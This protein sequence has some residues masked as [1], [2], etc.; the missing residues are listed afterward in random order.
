MR[1]G[2]SGPRSVPEYGTWTDIKTRCLNPNASNY[3][4]YGGRGITICKRWLVFENFLADM[5]ERPSSKHSIERIDNNGNYVPVNCRWATQTQQA[6]NKRN[7]VILTHEGRTA[8]IAEWSEITGV[9]RF[10]LY[11]RIRL[12]KMTPAEALTRPVRESVNG[13][14]GTCG[15]K[16]K[17]S[18]RRCRGC[19]AYRMRQW[20]SKRKAQG[21]V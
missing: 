17:H 7:N 13:P 15:R 16:G 3:A 10:T 9:S 5:G 11:Q 4:N 19:H 14:I 2:K 20:T 8:T 21:G 18:S 1:L 6:R 12:L